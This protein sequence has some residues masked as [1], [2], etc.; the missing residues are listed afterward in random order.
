ME[1]QTELPRY[2]IPL[3]QEGGYPQAAEALNLD[4]QIDF[5]QTEQ[6]IHEYCWRKGFG[7][8]FAILTG[9]CQFRLHQQSRSK[10][11]QRRPHSRDGKTQA[12]S[13]S[14]SAL[15]CPSH[16]TGDKIN[17]SFQDQQYSNKMNCQTQGLLCSTHFA[18]ATFNNE[19]ENHLIKKMVCCLRSC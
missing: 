14:D 10:L 7:N 1:R 19:L 17:N 6:S 13:H 8:C 18:C 3:D 4:P 11:G 16:Q 2:T 9:F 12:F 15:S 5:I